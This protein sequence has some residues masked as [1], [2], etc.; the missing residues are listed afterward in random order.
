MLYNSIRIIFFVTIIIL[1]VG[2]IKPSLVI[3]WG[4]TKTR[5]RVLLICTVP[6]LFLVIIGVLAISDRKVNE[7]QIVNNTDTPAQTSSTQQAPVQIKMKEVMITKYFD[8]IVNSA[9]VD[10][11]IIF[12]KSYKRRIS[13][14]GSKYLVLN[15]TA[16]NTDNESRFV[17]EGNVIID[18]NGRRLTYDK[19]ENIFEDGWGL[20]EQINPL[21]S[22]TANVVIKLPSEITGTTYYRPGRNDGSLI[23]IG[24]IGQ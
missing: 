2:L 11:E 3:P 12:Q 14:N 16:K 22:K 13:E 19:T 20:A 17:P 18:Y 21:A 24:E 23:Y 6:I 10:S 15:I 4:R 1:V 7:S 8:I 5:G 9:T